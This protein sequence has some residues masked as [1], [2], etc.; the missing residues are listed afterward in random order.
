M[1]LLP[2]IT[3]WWIGVLN[4]NHFYWAARLNITSVSPLY[5]LTFAYVLVLTCSG[6][7]VPGSGRQFLLPFLDTRFTN[8]IKACIRLCWALNPRKIRGAVNVPDLWMPEI[9]IY[10]YS[11]SHYISLTLDT[12]RVND[13]GC[14]L[15]SH[16]TVG[17]SNG[18]TWLYSTN[19]WL[20]KLD[21]FH[22]CT[23]LSVLT[24]MVKERG[25]HKQVWYSPL[26]VMN[27]M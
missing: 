6:L 24:C 25:R 12:S 17:G 3:H 13:V 21:L 5:R 20:V 22:L 1:S 14:D 4:E 7:F 26:S 27:K 23:V 8:W 9:T 18:M 15:W 16:P 2:T 11:R 10:F 19:L